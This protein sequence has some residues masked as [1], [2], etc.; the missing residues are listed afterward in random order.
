MKGSLHTCKRLSNVS[1]SIILYG[2]LSSLLSYDYMI[3]K[4]GAGILQ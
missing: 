3:F 1:A 4:K 2:D